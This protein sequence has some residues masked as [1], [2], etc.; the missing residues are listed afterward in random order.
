MIILREKAYSSRIYDPF[1]NLS[2]K[3]KDFTV[4]VTSETKTR[5]GKI[6]PC[7]TFYYKDEIYCIIGRDQSGKWYDILRY[8]YGLKHL[9][10]RPKPIEISENELVFY[11]VNEI[12]DLRDEGV[13]SNQVCSNVTR[14]LLNNTK[15]KKFTS[16]IPDSFKVGTDSNGEYM[17]TEVNGKKYKR[18]KNDDPEYYEVLKRKYSNHFKGEKI[19]TEKK[20]KAIPRAVAAFNLHNMMHQEQ[21]YRAAVRNNNMQQAQRV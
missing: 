21:A 16:V 12:E 19:N 10:T 20:S 15:E 6:D 3:D 17:E 5:L 2:F 11:L 13:I 18:Y 1:V 4:K 14:S 8:S 7:Y 9:F